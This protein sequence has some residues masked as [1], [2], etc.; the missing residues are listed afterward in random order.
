LTPTGRLPYR[1]YGI[2]HMFHRSHSHIRLHGPIHYARGGCGH[3]H[4]SNAVPPRTWMTVLRRLVMST[5]KEA[6]SGPACGGGGQ[7][8]DGCA[9]DGA[10]GRARYPT[11]GGA[12]STSHG[13][14]GI[15]SRRGAARRHC[16]R[17]VIGNRRSRVHHRPDC[18]NY[19]DVASW[20]RVGSAARPRPRAQ[21]VSLLATVR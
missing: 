19:A 9:S 14:H 11:P 3:R 15:H 16:Q 10:F 6:Q 4:R 21:A 20:N 17:A 7:T 13:A 5:A 1:P 8:V 18:L 12:R 2:R